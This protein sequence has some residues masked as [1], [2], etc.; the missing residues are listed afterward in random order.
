MNSIVI[1]RGTAHQALAEEV[2][3]HLNVPLSS[4]VTERFSNDCLQTKLEANCR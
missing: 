1:F 3:D 4:S 2:C